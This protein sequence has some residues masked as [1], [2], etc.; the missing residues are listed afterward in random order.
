MNDSA[1]LRRTIR[2]CTA[3]LIAAI[4]LTGFGLLRGRGAG[5]ITLLLLIL[6]SLLY[7]AVEFVRHTPGQLEAS[8]D[9]SRSDTAEASGEYQ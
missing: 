2:R 8:E 6:G 7:F 4:G 5:E 3:A 9:S 1:R